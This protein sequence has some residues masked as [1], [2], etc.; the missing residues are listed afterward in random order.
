MRNIKLIIAYEGTQYLGWQKTNAGPSIEETLERVLHQILQ[1]DVFLQAAGR[2]DAGVHAVGQVVNF[3]ASKEHLDFGR[4]QISLNALL[5]KDIV[6]LEATEEHPAFHPTLDCEGKEY[7]YYICYGTT[8]L[9]QHRR[10]SWHYHY[11]LDL[12]EMEQASQMLIGSHNFHLFAMP[13]KMRITKILFAT[14]PI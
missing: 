11:P 5:P 6:V 2:T 12:D 9:P 3:I 13:R 10:F 4:L 14:C 7:R 8:Q 1:Q